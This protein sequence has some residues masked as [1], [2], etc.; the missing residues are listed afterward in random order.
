MKIMTGFRDAVRR[1]LLGALHAR[2]HLL[3]FR[4]DSLVA[5]ARESA[6]REA[7]MQLELARLDRC[8]DGILEVRLAVSG[9][10]FAGDK[11]FES[12][13]QA[14]ANLGNG[15]HDLR[16]T[17]QEM[18]QK[19]DRLLLLLEPKAARL[20]AGRPPVQDWDTVQQQNLTQFEEKSNG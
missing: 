3:S 15:Q 19:I 17:Q 14:F 10:R 6:E 2:M 18:E 4:V 1:W 11:R 20:R 13:H 12:D 7:A 9:L 8:L 5:I 16:N